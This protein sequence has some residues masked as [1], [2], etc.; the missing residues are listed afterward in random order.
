[1]TTVKIL[2]KGQITLPK[3]IRD[4]LDLKI[5]DTLIIE[6]QKEHII[7]KKV[8]T[9]FDMAGTLPNTGVLIE[10]MI[11]NAIAEEYGKNN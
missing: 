6:E 2:A 7:I 9:I 1:M 8:N 5:G 10:E 11:D 4:A 3:K